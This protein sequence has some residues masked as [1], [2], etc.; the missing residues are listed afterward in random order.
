MRIRG[1]TQN[2]IGGAP[3]FQE[4]QHIIFPNFT[5]KLV[6]PLD[7]PLVILIRALTEHKQSITSNYRQLWLPN[8]RMS[9]AVSNIV[10]VSVKKNYTVNSVCVDD[11]TAK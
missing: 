11:W 4:A 3:T 10:E 6:T 5:K 8:Y 7:P 2:S 9:V 1:W